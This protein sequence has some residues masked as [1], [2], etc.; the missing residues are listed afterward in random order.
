MALR[1]ERPSSKFAP[2]QGFVFRSL[3]ELVRDTGRAD[4]AYDAIPESRRG[5]LISADIARRLAPEFETWDGRDRHT[6]STSSPAGAYAHDRVL[7]ELALPR[8]RKRLVITAGGPG[9]GKTTSLTA[10]A[11]GAVDLV[12]D[13]QFRDLPRAREILD[14]ALQHG[15]EIEVMYVHRPF[16]EVPRAVI[17]RSQRTGRW[18]RLRDLPKMHLDAR[19][20]IGVLMSEYEK[21][22]ILFQGTMNTGVR[23]RRVF[24]VVPSYLRDLARHANGAYDQLNHAWQSPCKDS[25]KKCIVEGAI[26]KELAEII[27]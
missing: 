23:R 26:C 5:R 20:A 2:D 1:I 9:S 14:R 6:P 8:D 27:G 22:G 12:F 4:R 13:N 24:K 15:W 17:E 7:R 18:N 25:L 19:Q 10:E 16:H 3:S 11:I 21:F